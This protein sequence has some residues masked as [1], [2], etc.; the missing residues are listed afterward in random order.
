MNAWKVILISAGV[1]VLVVF[2]GDFGRNRMNDLVD[3]IG[4][5]E[6]QD[7]DQWQLIRSIECRCNF[8]LDFV[9]KDIIPSGWYTL[10]PTPKERTVKYRLESIESRLDA[11]EK[12]GAK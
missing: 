4:E 11:L 3:R 1:S 9:G 5:N 7:F 6:N 12:G 2:G 10:M 8:I